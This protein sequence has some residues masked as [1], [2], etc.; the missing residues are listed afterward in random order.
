MKKLLFA[1]A[2]VA[3]FLLAVNPLRLFDHSYFFVF[4]S[5]DLRRAAEL[6]A[7]N[8]VFF[9]PEITGGGNLPGPFYYY[10]LAPALAFGGWV[11][12]WNW[13]FVLYCAGMAAG[14][15]YFWRRYSA[16]A[17]A[18]FTV[19][20]GT[21]PLTRVFLKIFLNVSYLPAFALGALICICESWRAS[22]EKARTRALWGAFL[23][24]GLGVQLHLSIAAWAAALLALQW[25]RKKVPQAGISGR[26]FLAGLGFFALPLVPWAI[27]YALDQAG[28]SLGQQR[29]FV[30]SEGQVLPTYLGFLGFLREHSPAELVAQ[31]PKL[32]EA[33]PF[34]LL[35]LVLLRALAPRASGGHASIAAPALACALFG[36]VPFSF[37][38]IVP[39]GFRYG[40][41]LYL[42]LIFLAVEWLHRAAADAPLRRRFT[43][44][45]LLLSMVGAF[46]FFT[47]QRSSLVKP[48]IYLLVAL[49]AMLGAAA[50]EAGKRA[51]TGML[52][53]AATCLSLGQRD[54]IDS[55]TFSSSYLSYGIMPN[56]QA[57]KGIWRQVYGATGWTYEEARSRIFFLHHHIEQDP[58]PLY[59][60][61]VGGR[62]PPQ[63]DGPRPDGFF[64]SVS[65]RNGKDNLA[66]LLA[67]PLPPELSRALS[68]GAIRLGEKSL[69]PNFL[70]LPYF[71]ERPAEVPAL[72]HNTGEGYFR[73]EEAGTLARFTGAEEA[74]R[75]ADGSITFHWN[76]CPGRN[77]YCSTAAVVSLERG[78]RG[79]WKAKVRLIG[80]P[81]SQVSPWISPEWTESWQE[82]YLEIGCAGRIS[83][84]PIAS[85]V[86][87]DRALGVQRKNY[88]F[89]FNHSFIAPFEREIAFRC[90]SGPDSVA[91]GRKATLVESIRAVRALPPAHLTYVMRGGPK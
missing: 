67:R 15:V 2:A 23:L 91:V 1:A 56:F 83:R 52:L 64:I 27:W 29:T 58:Q 71:V 68:T 39:I 13:M 50:A 51:A 46:V 33:V 22:T 34:V 60:S 42:P 36:L 32:F 80:S 9:G 79:A 24:L 28:V 37:Y 62:A 3:A 44:A 30:G 66:W 35:L 69:S 75:N 88:P 8:P 78:A 76:E 43:R 54:M 11:A 17:A 14:A 77:P 47:D 73:T 90:S 57:W 10:L 89:N 72:I 74:V 19:L 81:I 21:S 6:L 85:A 5:R 16:F 61:T 86:G 84:F 31:I 59:E 38:L 55:G 70:V 12:A 53:V 49:A 4:Q 41:P 45:G 20:L 82:P 87:Y 18:A 40:L 63:P 26:G 65:K 25:M 7:G 48:E